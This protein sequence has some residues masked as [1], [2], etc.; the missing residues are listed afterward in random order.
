[1][2][3]LKKSG[4][5]VAVVTSRM[6][7]SAL[8]GLEKF[9]LTSELDVI[10]TINDITRHKPDPESINV[11]LKALGVGP[12]EAVMIG[13]SRFDILCAQNADC[14]SIL[15]DWSVMGAEERA[16]IKADYIGQNAEDI[17][18]WINEN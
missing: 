8:E 9:G 7:Q 14:R 4:Y 11:T 13:D 6:K 5:K 15:V 17:F 12:D 18:N 1:M 3:K 2:K 16:N 10:T